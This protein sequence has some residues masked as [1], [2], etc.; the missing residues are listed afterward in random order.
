MTKEQ[1]LLKYPKPD[2][3]PILLDEWFTPLGYCWGEATTIDDEKQWD[4][5][6]NCPC[7]LFKTTHNC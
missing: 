4:E 7:E 2:K 1:F 5:D 3:C 6:K